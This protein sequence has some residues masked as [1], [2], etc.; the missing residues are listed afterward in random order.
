MILSA[1]PLIF[2]QSQFIL[3]IFIKI[4]MQVKVLLIWMVWP[5]L[6]GNVEDKLI[7]KRIKLSTYK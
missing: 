7:I 3:I 6:I 4:V 1:Y 5:S 2:W